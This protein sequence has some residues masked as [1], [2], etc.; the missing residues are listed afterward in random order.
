MAGL[1]AAQSL[2]RIRQECRQHADQERYRKRRRLEDED[3]E[4]ATPY[5]RRCCVFVFVLGG[6]N[7]QTAAEYLNS[8]RARRGARQFPVEQL[9]N[10]IL[11]WFVEWPVD[12]LCVFF[13]PITQQDKRIYAATRRYCEDRELYAWV[14]DQ[15]TS[16]GLAPRTSAL[17]DKFDEI[18]A[19]RRGGAGG[20]CDISRADI[21]AGRNRTFFT[22]WR[23]RM[24]VKIGN[25]QPSGHMEEVE[26]RTKV[27]IELLGMR[28]LVC[29][30]CGY[31]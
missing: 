26:K 4:H 17:A 14:A 5:V 20:P 28:V 18:R 1:D 30:V 24:N 31:V 7:A 10:T 12:E 6:H 16:R 23:R 9:Q 3:G 8:C 19:L 27:P 2:A 15:N 22:R 13:E 25:L 11:G 29:W 21:G